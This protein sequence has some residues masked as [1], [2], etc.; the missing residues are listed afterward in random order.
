MTQAQFGA[1]LYDA[2]CTCAKVQ[3]LLKIIAIE[4]HKGRD[5]ADLS[6]QYGR[7]KA[8]AKKLLEADALSTEDAARLVREHPWLM[9]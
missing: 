9:A 5:T 6:A 7:E 4:V 3:Q 8:K 1:E 2:I